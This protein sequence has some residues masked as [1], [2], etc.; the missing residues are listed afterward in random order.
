[1][2]V[3]GKE[4]HFSVE[5]FGLFLEQIQ[6]V[7]PVLRVTLHWEWRRLHL[8]FFVGYDIMHFHRE[9]VDVSPVLL[10]G[11]LVVGKR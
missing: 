1:L 8:P 3:V 10:Q 4:A 6:I 7:L 11:L 5:W 2:N 9:G